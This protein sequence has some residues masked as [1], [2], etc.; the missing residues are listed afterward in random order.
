LLGQVLKKQRGYSMKIGI[1]G[2]THRNIEYLGK[3]ADWLIERQKIAMVYHLGD[4]YDDVKCL[5]EKYIDIV[6]VP[7][8]YDE[9]Y[10]NGSLPKTVVENVLGLRIL[11]VHTLDKDVTKDDKLMSDI[12]LYGH[13]HKYEITL[14]DGLLCMNP[15]HLKGPKDKNFSPTF[16]LLDIQDTTLSAKIFGL[17]FKPVLSMELMRAESRL[18]KA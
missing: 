14:S 16:G 9:R 12:I 11:L 7:G 5:S 1:V 4:D 18:Y 2:D 10:I 8:I 15:G 3:V 13:T 17:D 6:Q